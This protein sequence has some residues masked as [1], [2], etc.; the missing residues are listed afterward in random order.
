M[1]SR[2]TFNALA[3]STAAS[4]FAG[5]R[6]YGQ[7]SAP[8]KIGIMNDMSGTAAAL[9]GT[10]SVTA[11]RMAIEDFGGQVLGRKVELL[12]ADHQNKPDVGAGIARQ[13]F[14]SEGVDAIFGLSVSSVAF[15]VRGLARERGKI[16]VNTAAASSELTNSQCS[17]TGFHWVYD[18]YS[19]AAGA[20]RSIVKSGNDSWFFVSADYTFGQVL[21]RDVSKFVTEAG[22]KILGSIP[23][24]LGTTDCS[25]H[26]LR[27]QSSGAK[28]IALATGG[29]DIVNCIKQASEF[30]IGGANQKLASLVLLITDIHALGTQAAKGLL[31]TE[32]F[33]WNLNDETRKWSRRFFERQKT[34]PNMIQEGDYSAILHYLRAVQA[35]GKTDGRAVSEIM[36][37]T[38]VKEVGAAD[39]IIRAD[40]RVLRDMHLFEVKSPAESKE[41]WDYYKLV[42]TLPAAEAFQPME[43]GTCPADRRV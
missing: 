32:S 23:L 39:S 16:D 35:A 9:T 22:G 38:P 13:W 14:D 43:A 36:H 8:L 2:R 37:K 12:V 31:L 40:G 33:Y 24:P 28:V 10:A 18:T 34:M 25:T 26:L 21:Q 42:A 7:T 1:L 30:G 17:P 4:A 15:A 27:G 3:G 20:A 41:A 5:G 11:A 6:A 29:N 19:L